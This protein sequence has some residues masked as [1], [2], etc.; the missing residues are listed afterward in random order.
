VYAENESPLDLIWIESD[1]RRHPC[2]HFGVPGEEGGALT[3]YEAALTVCADPRCDCYAVCCCCRPALPDDSPAAAGL[4]H[5]FWLDVWD[6]SVAKTPELKAAPKTLEFAE[7]IQ[8]RLSEPAWNEL[9]RW[10]RVAKPEVI[11]TTEVAEIEIDDLPNSDGARMVSFVDVFP[12]GLALDFSFENQ[13]WAADEQYCVQPKC[14][15]KETVLSFLR[16]ADS[17][18]RKFARLPK[19]PAVRYNYRIGTTSKVSHG[20]AGTPTPEQLLSALKAACALLNE[21]LELRH[22]IM[23]SLYDRH[24]ISRLNAK[25]ESLAGAPVARA[26]KKPGRNDPCPCGSGK[27]FKKCCGA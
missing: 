17:S 12:R 11:Q 13:L 19:L 24:N 16:Y 18:G 27:K 2:L 5:K 15:C 4:S 10:F 9:Y 7:S 1:G 6:R 20:A 21:Q 25:L 26:V 8:A 3:R 22:C 14:D 23:Q